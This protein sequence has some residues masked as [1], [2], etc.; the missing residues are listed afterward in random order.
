MI[1]IA[2]CHCGGVEIT[3]NG[4]PDPVILCHCKLCQRR[5]GGLFH[6]AAWFESSLVSI[7]G[8]TTEFTRTA[9]D[10]NLPFT[11]HFCPTCGTS[12]WWLSPRPD[13]PLAGKIGIAGGCFAEPNFP[14]PTISIYE[15]HKHLWITPPTDVQKFNQG[16]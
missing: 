2:R 5:T 6:I 4:E 9:G 10:A 16:I 1:H 8:E 12:I 11:F 7:V 3:C 15:E 13:G 14:V